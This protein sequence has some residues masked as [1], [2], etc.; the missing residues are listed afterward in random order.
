[1]KTCDFRAAACQCLLGNLLEFWRQPG[2]DRRL[3][4]ASV[5]PQDFASARA[6]RYEATHDL[7]AKP[8]ILWIMLQEI[9]RGIDAG[10]GCAWCR[11]TGLTL[12]E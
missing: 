7:V 1:V 6:V 11:A 12:A 8:N 5:P 4:C 3:V 2:L 9:C 10:C